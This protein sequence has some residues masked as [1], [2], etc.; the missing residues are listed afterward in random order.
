MTK[1]PAPLST[2]GNIPTWKREDFFTR[3]D[4]CRVM[5]NLHDVLSD[6]E[7]TKVK[8]RITKLRAKAA[9]P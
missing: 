1:H 7:N 3:L 6:A 9:K 5:L 4:R 2:E 8:L